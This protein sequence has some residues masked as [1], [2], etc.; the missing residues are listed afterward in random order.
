M[1]RPGV[2]IIALLLA[3]DPARAET[4]QDKADQLFMEG[5]ELIKTGNARGA[6]VKF[7]A[8]IALDRNAPG[9]ML[10]LGLC[11]EKLGKLATSLRWYRKAQVAASEAKPERLTDYEAAATAST[12]ELKSRVATVKIV[13]TAAPEVEVRIDGVILRGDDLAE[14]PIDAGSHQ[15][16]ARAPNKVSYAD[17]F[18]IANKDAKTIVVPALQDAHSAKD[19]VSTTNTGRK[20]QVIGIGIGIAGAGVFGGSVLYAKK[21]SD[22]F[23]SSGKPTNASARLNILT[24][25][26]IAG[27]A[28]V[29][30]GVYLVWTAP[31]REH[32]ATALAPVVTNDQVGFAVS[33]AF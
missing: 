15:F 24:G 27:V 16:E 6:C 3:S 25:T 32:N 12:A 22:D 13:V 14:Y 9:V 29:G 8:A 33:G 23:N 11:Y 7:E 19:V 31:K 4:P 20:R 30:L 2:L 1:R 18:T 17:R 10:N 5:R 21:V 28:A 26:G